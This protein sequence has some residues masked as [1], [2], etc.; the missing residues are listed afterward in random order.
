MIE[1][2]KTFEDDALIETDLCVIGAGAAGITIA[3]EFIGSKLQ[4]CL[5]E[6]GGFDFVLC[7]DKLYK[8]CHDILYT[9][10]LSYRQHHCMCLP[11]T[12]VDFSHIHMSITH[13]K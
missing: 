2:F 12:S 1:D 13:Q 6:S 7:Q 8:V 9:L 11:T 5:V 3:R 10:N 4:V